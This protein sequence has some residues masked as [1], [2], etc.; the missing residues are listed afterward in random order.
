MSGG[1]GSVNGGFITMDID[2]SSGDYELKMID[3]YG[4]SWNG[5]IWTLTDN[6]DGTEVATCE[7]VSYGNI[8]YCN[9]SITLEGDCFGGGPDVGC[10]GICF[11]NAAEDECGVCDGGGIAEETCDNVRFALLF[12]V[13]RPGENNCSLL[14]RIRTAS[15]SRNT[16]APRTSIMGSE[17]FAP[18]ESPP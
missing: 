13:A 11:S 1:A 6:D 12:N 17:P 9:F 16:S 3:S 15:R 5:N 14:N 18:L 2:L 7:L 10:D 4:D 8:G